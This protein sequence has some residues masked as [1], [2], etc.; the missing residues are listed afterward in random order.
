MFAETQ[1]HPDS[2][3][4]NINWLYHPESSSGQV[5]TTKKQ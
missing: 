1:I 2:Y 3:R 4:E 5:M